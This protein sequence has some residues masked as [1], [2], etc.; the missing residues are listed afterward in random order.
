[1]ESIDELNHKMQ[2]CRECSLSQYDVNQ[3]R[4]KTDFGKVLG[5]GDGSKV[6]FVAMAPSWF[7]HGFYCF[8]ENDFGG[9]KL[10][11]DA[12]DAVGWDRESVYVTNLVKCSTYKNAPLE[13]HQIE[14]CQKFILKEIE[15]WKPKLIVPLGKQVAEFFG[16]HIYRKYLWHGYIV[17]PMYHPSFC[18]RDTEFRLQFIE[19]FKRIPKFIDEINNQRKLDMFDTPSKVNSK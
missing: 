8:R 4:E 17:F 2:S 6:V 15:I 18:C 11:H 12:L 3:R 13:E 19:E 10:F 7:R 14:M 5:Y 9:N 16:G 1:M